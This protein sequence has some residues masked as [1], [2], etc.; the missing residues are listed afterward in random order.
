MSSVRSVRCVC[1][2]ALVFIS[3]GA[4]FGQ[5]KIAWQS[6]GLCG[7]GGL[8]NPAVSPLDRNLIFTESDM[9]G[10]YVSRDGGK[11]WTMY[12][13]HMIGSACRGGPV[14]FSTAIP[15]KMVSSSGFGADTVYVSTDTGQSFKPWAPDRQPK[16]GLISRFRFDDVAG[17]RLIAGSNTGQLALSD[18]DG[19][20]WRKIQLAG[21]VYN[22]VFDAA[23][24]KDV[25]RYFVGTDKGVYLVTIPASGELKSQA[26]L[27][28]A[29]T[30][31][32]G[33]SNDKGTILYHTRRCVL[34]DGQ[35]DGGVYVSADQGKSWQRTMNPRINVETKRTSEWAAGDVPQY[36]HVLVNDKDPARCYVFGSG[37]SYF[38]P[39]HNTVYRTDDAGKSWRAVW[40]VD[41]RFKECNVG[42]DWMTSFRG[43]SWV[44]GPIHVEISPVDPDLVMWADGM[45]LF[46]TRD[47][48][49][50]WQPAYAYKL[51]PA[52]K[53]DAK[54]AWAHNG[55][56]NTTTWNYYVDPHQPNQHYIAYTDIGF[57]RSFDG[58]KSWRW[59]G[60][61]SE[62]D[63]ENGNEP[64]VPRAWINTCYELAFDPELPG[65][66]W[67]A[68]SGHH[69]IPNENS[70]W[71]GSGK[72]NG[73]GGICVSTDFGNVWKA[74][75]T[76]LPEAPALSV[77]LDPS[78]PKGKRTLYA[79]VYDHGV[80]KSTDDGA[81]WTKKSAGLGSPRNTRVVRL[82]RLADGTLYCL[83]TGMRLPPSGQPPAPG[84][85]TPPDPF[86]P[87]G[88]G[89]YRS[90]DAGEKW[91]LVTKAPVILYPRDFGV[92]P[93][94]PK[95]LYVG[96]SDT[97]GSEQGGLWRSTDGGAKWERI[98]RKR[99]THFGAYFHPKHPDWVYA[100]C[101]GWSASPEGSLFLSK[102]NGKTWAAFPELPFAQIARV[103]V[104]PQDPGIIYC[105][106]FGGSVWEGP[107]EP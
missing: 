46:I 36:R 33:G 100:T 15:G 16:I 62:L 39:N 64:T 57:A 44:S 14:A 99:A 20:T 29:L 18:D 81:S 102:D 25:R 98:I 70:I 52:E 23:S 30:G 34:K 32:G 66:L 103:T 49:K 43:K 91:E 42:R 3:A 74:T 105:T 55:L 69:D 79:A 27:Q 107:A 5:A 88:V 41:P 106:T 37:T 35:L 56:V 95:V 47:G 50:N 38:P 45:W 77:I 51:D 75:V 82:Q 104:D 26:L 93:K 94:D 59:W 21:D 72:S 71:R 76:G 73:K 8:M 7:G 22:I 61:G 6:T 19:A 90:T 87:V 89:L 63:E 86:D 4:A 80:F 58:G 10:K 9:G 1:V 60:P 53:S 68:F 12:N 2:L 92:D 85:R 97:P 17:N 48:G 67:G 78:S 101:T 24:G 13:H 28:E 31:F 96:A 84:T 40:F 54:T 65:K 11:T 83:V